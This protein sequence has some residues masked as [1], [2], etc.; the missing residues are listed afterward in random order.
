MYR[1]ALADTDLDPDTRDRLIRA[2][3]V[4]TGAEA[5]IALLDIAGAGPGEARATVVEIADAVLA[6]YLGPG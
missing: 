2:L 5:M 1:L 4:G 6:R 3:S